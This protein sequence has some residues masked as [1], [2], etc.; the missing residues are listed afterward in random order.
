MSMDYF[1]GCK[2]CGLCLPVLWIN[3]GGHC[4]TPL[5]KPEKAE[6]FQAFM[7]EH[8]RHGLT[9]LTERDA[10]ELD[11]PEEREDPK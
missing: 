1:I 11:T 5:A 9:F 10:A 6:Q 4:G 7:N 8:S 3:A 2:E